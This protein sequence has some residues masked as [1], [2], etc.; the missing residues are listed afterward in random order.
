[1]ELDILKYCTIT[2]QKIKVDGKD[3]FEF[4]GHESPEM[5]LA[6]TYRQM[7]LNYLKFFKMDN[8]SKLAILGAE[9][10]F[11]DTIHYSIEDKGNYAVVLANAS[12]S[13]VTDTNFQKTISD[14]GN[15]FPSPSL[16]VY[17]LPNITIGEICIKHKIYGEN[18]FLVSQRFS[19]ENIYFY[20]NDL[21][22]KTNTYNCIAGWAECSRNYFEAFLFL[23]EKGKQGNPFEV[24]E[25]NKLYKTN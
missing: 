7:G 13:L 5:S 9:A 21:F 23:V 17:T 25:L 16:F 4:E 15:Y 1:M 14:P 12:S 24:N 8:L 18:V 20:V 19:A 22:N 6:R 3:L 11:R 10:I 2:P